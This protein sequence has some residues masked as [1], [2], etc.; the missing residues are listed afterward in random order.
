MYCLSHE[1]R[2]KTKQ[3]KTPISIR[4]F[5]EHKKTSAFLLTAKFVKCKLTHTFTKK[6]RLS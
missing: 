5:H 3:D 2:I 6:K 1:L 4:L